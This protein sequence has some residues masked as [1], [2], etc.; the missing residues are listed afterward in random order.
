MQSFE[1]A[2]LKMYPHILV[3]AS[4]VLDNWQYLTKFL[5]QSDEKVKM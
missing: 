1:K 5:T 3:F 4:D 2:V